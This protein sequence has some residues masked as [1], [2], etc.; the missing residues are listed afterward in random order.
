MSRKRISLPSTLP[1]SIKLLGFRAFGLWVGLK[2][3]DTDKRGEEETGGNSEKTRAVREKARARTCAA[4]P[5]T[6]IAPSDHF[7]RNALR[8]CLTQEK[9]R[10]R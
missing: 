5:D 8:S 2:G 1:L 6:N 7:N 4:I 3:K 9:N 10:Q